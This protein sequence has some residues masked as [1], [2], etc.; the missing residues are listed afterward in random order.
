LADSPRDARMSKRPLKNFG[1]G[2][3]SRNT[4]PPVNKSKRRE[5]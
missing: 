4:V 2:D 3:L 1:I 5:P